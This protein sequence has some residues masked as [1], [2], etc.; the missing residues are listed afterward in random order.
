[1]I[2]SSNAAPVYRDQDLN[3][4]GVGDWWEQMFFQGSCVATND[5]DGDGLINLYEYYYGTNPLDDDTDNNRVADG[6]EYFRT[7]KFSNLGLQMAAIDPNGDYDLDGLPNALE[8]RLGCDPALADTGPT[9]TPDGS[10]DFDGDG[11]PNALELARGTDP[12]LID[13]DDDGLSDADE[14]RYGLAATNSLSPARLMVLQVSGTDTSY[15]LAPPALRFALTN[16][17]ISARV[18]PT[19]VP[20]AGVIVAREV[21][22]NR[23][24]YYLGMNSD[25]RPFIRFSDF[26][27]G[28]TVQVIAPPLSALPLNAWSQ[29]RASFDDQTGRLSLYMNG[30]LLASDTTTRRPARTGVGTVYTRVGK[31]IAGYIDDVQIKS[32]PT[33]VV[34]K[35]SFDDGTHTNGTSGKSTWTTG[36]VQDFA[37]DMDQDWLTRWQNAG[38]LTNAAV[39]FDPTILNNGLD[40]DGDGLQ[41]WWEIRFGLN[42]Y[43]RDSFGDGI[44]DANRDMSGDGLVNSYI[45]RMDADHRSVLRADPRNP[46]NPYTGRPL[47]SELAP[48]YLEMKL[49]N[50]LTNAEKQQYGL[51]PLLEDTDD[52]GVSDVAEVRGTATALPQFTLANAS[53]SPA[54]SGALKVSGS[55]FV[56]M[57]SG[58]A[59]LVQDA[60]W[61]VEAWVSIDPAFGGNGKL[62]QRKVGASSVNYELGFT[63]G[64]PYVLL[65]GMYGT[66]LYNHVAAGPVTLLR[67]NQW[68]HLAGIY[69]ATAKELSLF[70]DGHMVAIAAVDVTPLMGYGIGNA[71]ARVGEGFRGLLDEVRIWNVAQDITNLAFNAYQTFENV[72]KGPSLYYRFDDG[73]FGTNAP[74]TNLLG[75]AIN[76]VEDFATDPADWNQNWVHA[77]KLVGDAIMVSTNTPIVATQFVDQDADDLPDFWEIAAF[78]SISIHKGSDDPD[79]DGLT[80]YSEYRAR[81]DPLTEY[82]FGGTLSDYDRDS[83]GDRLS[84]GMEQQLGTMPDMF[85]TDDD[86][87]WDGDEVLGVDASGNR[88]GISDPLSSLNPLGPRAL[89]LNGNARVVV[90]AQARQ[91]MDQQFTLSAWVWPSNNIPVGSDNI[92][93]ARTLSDGSVNYE[94]GVANRSGTLRPYVRYTGMASGT[95]RDIRVE[96]GLS[97]VTTLNGTTNLDWV[98]PQTWTHIAASYQAASNTLK[99]FVSGELVAW[100]IDAVQ[101]P[102]TGAGANLP[103]GGELTLGGGRLNLNGV[104]VTNG[105]EGYIDDVRIAAYAYSGES[106]RQMAGGQMV[107]VSNAT[108]TNASSVVSLQSR[109]ASLSA[110]TSAKPAELIVGM[111]PSAVVS[112]S[113]SANQKAM[114]MAMGA[115]LNGVNV[116]KS[117]DVI[118]AVHVQI[119]DGTSASAKIAELM[120]DSR[121]AY[122]EPN[123]SLQLFDTFPND[124]RFGM[125]WG[126]HNTGTN[127]PG[128]GVADADIDAPTAWDVSVGKPTVI[129]AV[130]DTGIDYNHPDLKNNMWRNP[131]EIPGNG[132]DDDGN[133]Y[134]DDVYGYDFGAGDADPMDD[135][136]GHGTHVAGIIGASGNDGT[137]VCGVNWNVKL[138]ALKI[139]DSAGGLSLD[140]ALAA[141]EYAWKNG[142]RVS[143]NSWGGYGYSQA[144]YDAIKAAGDNNHLFCAAAANDSNDNDSR[145]AYPASYDLDNI[146]AVAATDN[147]DALAYFSNYGATTVDLGA[148]GVEIMSTLPLGGSEMGSTYG[149][150]SGTS[151]ATPFVA[152]AAG[153]VLSADDKLSCAALKAAILN[154]VDPD[155]ALVGKT[156]TGGRLNIGNILPK[157]GGGG[158]GGS[159]IVNGLVGLFRFDD[160]G[161][162]VEDFTLTADWRRNWRYAGQL[163]AGAAMTTN[164]AYLATGD[165]DGDGLPDW[166]ETA[167]G[168]DPRNGEGGSGSSGDPDGDGLSNLYEYRAGTDPHEYDTGN[169]G[170]SD[171]DKD[172]DGDGISNGEEQ[173]VFLTDPGNKDTDDDGI[174]DG[175]ELRHPIA[176]LS[177]SGTDPT[178]SLSP[179]VDRA[180]EFH[181]GTGNTVV[182]YDK[183]NNR[184][185]SRYS[186]PEWTIEAYVNPYTN[187]P[188]MCPLVS[189]RLF[190]NGRRNYEIG[191]SDGIPYVAF[192][193]KDSGIPVI[194]SLA[195]TNQAVATNHWTHIAAR[196]TLGLNG[197][198]NELALFVDGVNVVNMYL[199]WECETGPGDL[200]LGSDG[201]SGMLSDVRLWKIPRDYQAIADARQHKLVFGNS[202]A[203]AGRLHLTG[204]GYLKETAVTPNPS[205]P[206][207]YID[208]L[209]NNWTLECWVKTDSSGVSLIERRNQ[210]APTDDNF[211][212]YF[213][214]GDDGTLFARFAIDYTYV[215]MTAAGPAL[216]YERNFDFNNIYGSI[217][218]NDSQ[219]HHV[220]YV[221]SD[222]GCYLFVD[223]LLDVSQDRMMV[224]PT[225]PS[226]SYVIP[227][228]VFAQPGPCRFGDGV[229][230]DMDEIRIWN[231]GLPTVELKS[232]SARNLT[233]NE[234]GLVSYFNFDFQIG[235]TADERSF[236]RDSI[237]EYGIYIP[238]ASRLAGSA[239]GAPISYNPLLAIQRVALSG[240]FLCND[241]GETVEDFVYPMGVAPFNF[242]AYAGWRG[243]SVTWTNLTAANQPYPTDSDG[244]GMPDWW[245]VWYDLDPSEASGENG[246]WGDP[247]HDGLCNAA[248]YLANTDPRNP[249]TLGSGYMDYDSRRNSIS[250]TFGELY[251]PMDSL[252]ALW[253]AVHNLDPTQYVAEKDP[254]HDYWSSYAE[255]MAGTDPSDIGSLPMPSIQA[256]FWYAG[257]VKGNVQI[258]SYTSAL[259]DGSPDA[260]FVVEQPG[261]SNQTV[262]LSVPTTGYL[263]E[264]D[265]WFFAFID[266]DGSGEWDMGEP[267]GY[268]LYQPVNVGWSSLD[269]DFILQDNAMGFPRIK[270]TVPE[271][272]AVSRVK[273]G[274]LYMSGPATNFWPV[275]DLRLRA[276]RNYLTEADMLYLG[277]TN[278]MGTINTGV[279]WNPQ[280]SWSVDFDPVGVVPDTFVADL[281]YS[282]FVQK[283]GTAPFTTPTIV[284]PFNETVRSLPLQFEWKAGDDVAAFTLELRQNSTTG[285]VVLSTM[286]RAP[287]YRDSQGIAHYC[288]MPQYARLGFLAIPDGIYY[289]RVTPNNYLTIMTSTPSDWSRVVVDTTGAYLPASGITPVIGPFSISGELEYFGKVANY[290]LD[291]RVFAGVG[292]TGTAA[293]VFSNKA[294]TNAVVTPGSLTLRLYRGD[295]A[296]A[297]NLV[298]FTDAGAT[299]TN[300]AS[301][302]LK[303]DSNRS[304]AGWL[305]STCVVNYVSGTVLSAVF[306]NPTT[307]NDVFAATYRYQGYPFIVQAYPLTDVPGFS[308]RPVAQVTLQKKGAFTLTGLSPASY[309]LLGFIDQNGDGRMRPTETWGFVR[310]HVPATGPGYQE[311]RSLMVGPSVSESAGVK[312]IL[313]DRDTDNDKLPDAW[314]IQKFGSIAAHS[315]EEVLNTKTIWQAYA[316]GPLDANPN[317]FDS[318]FDGLPD[319]LELALGFDTHSPESLAGSGLGDL[320]RYIG[321]GKD[322]VIPIIT[323]DGSGHPVIQWHS[324][325]VPV[326][327]YSQIRYKVLRTTD[328]SLGF[329]PVPGAEDIL[330][331]PGE[332]AQSRSF[333]DLDAP[334][335]AFYKLQ[336]VVEPLL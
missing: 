283:W 29:L 246:P 257:T 51:N 157:T 220:A 139:A 5:P 164:H 290:A 2:F 224:D 21:Q 178:S 100:R 40:S 94:L 16:F 213:G 137:G 195:S 205:R 322:F 176:D 263:R 317:E 214:I 95:A 319:G 196:F 109:A 62:I 124:T 289:W 27:D 22:T 321:E 115:S 202:D 210:S 89:S 308:G 175:I 238:S 101:L 71:V 159:V 155:E 285:S 192:D 301:V 181:A 185:T 187:A 226:L 204:T 328:L 221:R 79:G 170:K 309:V 50:G 84:N 294:L 53:L 200:V 206:N 329:A 188:G 135:V 209:R 297:S 54:R 327:G 52:D 88:K 111:R 65:S 69:D 33:N 122:V 280:Y 105:F 76:L 86:G 131:G 189:R 271:G 269:V 273:V 239:N 330:A 314:E 103:L 335:G 276:P 235:K 60:S 99:L 242:S 336:A 161:T 183:V 291:E 143:N 39:I 49:T 279:D 102:V 166:W 120:A 92:V 64:Y 17:D 41:D 255:Y 108:S 154:N 136:I 80:N 48:I 149:Y 165:S 303:V 12:T 168:L 219:W 73:P 24:N 18:Y 121:V 98:V 313:R 243:A 66:N 260:V 173:D 266:T 163:S 56:D 193:A 253:K 34:M 265:T 9:G 47:Q 25:M 295:I 236:L 232:V 278:G 282:T 230:G 70:V 199:S 207:D 225:I 315:G 275:V 284:S 203:S 277:K 287:Y 228:A 46:L 240:L 177:R 112:L 234:L 286:V 306:Q 194:L 162:T 1:M 147:R 59:R 138:M 7:N 81:L 334:P 110:S 169:T 217:P 90:P 268:A 180:L 148:P 171:Y 30:H 208:M 113:S 3:G 133:G 302:T 182:A 126:L 318:D 83:D 281:P 117:Y 10:K 140:A 252:P 8:L 93:I 237:A 160:G 116:I 58:Q 125:Q 256:T 304:S 323:N 179:F 311:I 326:A 264:G 32:G 325:D 262:K 67:R 13:T 300:L 45:Y 97:G 44:D 4:N 14:I 316:D 184:F 258:E 215:V 61:T 172:S 190:L 197:K 87:T 244:D 57:P 248:E 296:A 299:F 130:I 267:C 201:F 15:V 261:I 320:E 38:T 250:L 82:T 118:S 247:D 186:M 324:P 211:N 222:K 23:Y 72:Y 333:T 227:P 42:P 132:I 270:W 77:G 128:S 151:M 114:L 249:D 26:A 167:N 6:F 153:L 19:N 31:G 274:Y 259:R 298:I 127:G 106:I 11:L 216:V 241:G 28:S 107:T 74:T 251:T 134:I 141:I 37:P 272:A 331:K 104:G 223:G 129:V 75:L 245:E 85:D 198:D 150:A 174:E 63:N 310:N 312:V 78:G 288:Y 305:S 218:V 20:T 55:G 35:Y 231:R 123:M 68:Y 229:T 119:T 36:Q 156:V 212:Y 144:L 293:R 152:G 91:A 142:A 146:I 233:G 332:A 145:P 191:L 292:G 254:D 158:A 43:A 307:T 96:A